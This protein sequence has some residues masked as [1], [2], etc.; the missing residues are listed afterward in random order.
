MNN[1][2]AV[3]PLKLVKWSHSDSKREIEFADDSYNR[4]RDV[5]GTSFSVITDKQ[6]LALLQRI[7]LVL[8]SCIYI[9]SD[10]YLS[11]MD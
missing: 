1:Q 5:C 11:C 9:T 4:G 6:I 8:C 7:T 2:V 3:L 10:C